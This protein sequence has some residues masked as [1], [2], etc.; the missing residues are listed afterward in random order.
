M[1]TVGIAGRAK[2]RY[3]KGSILIC[4]LPVNSFILASSGKSLTIIF[5]HGMQ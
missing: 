3:G 1:V 4:S 5:V 2:Y